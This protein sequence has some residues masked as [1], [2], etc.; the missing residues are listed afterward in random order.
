MDFGTRLKNLRNNKDLT[1]QDLANLMGVGRATIAGYETKGKQPDFEK[2]K[3]LANF[4]NVSIDW[5]LGNSNA[6]S[7]STTHHI[8]SSV[9]EDSELLDFT[10]ELMERESMQL[11]FKQA[12]PL[13][14]SD[15]GKIIKIIKAIEDEEDKQNGVD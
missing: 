3:W 15:I 8:L 1:Q 2:I 12:K 11:L 7:P 4:F 6:I 14:D 10:K 5:L 13:S 9:S